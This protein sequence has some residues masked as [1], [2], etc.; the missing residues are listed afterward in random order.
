MDTILSSC[1]VFEPVDLVR[2][3]SEAVNHT[4]EL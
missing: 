1:S 3:D 2:V 4:A